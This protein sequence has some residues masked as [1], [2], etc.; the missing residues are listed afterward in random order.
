MKARTITKY[1]LWF[2]LFTNVIPLSLAGF[3]LLYCSILSPENA[4]VYI[5][6]IKPLLQNGYVTLII[7]WLPYSIGFYAWIVS[8]IYLKKTPP[9][10]PMDFYDFLMKVMPPL[11]WIYSKSLKS[12]IDERNTLL[13]KIFFILAVSF[14]LTTFMW[15]WDFPNYVINIGIIVMTFFSMSI[16]IVLIPNNDYDLSIRHLDT[17]KKNKDEKSLL[18]ALKII[19][20]ILDN[21]ISTEEIYNMSHGISVIFS[22][23]KEEKIKRIIDG[24]ILALEKEDVEKISDLMPDLYFQNK[25][26]LSRFEKILKPVKMPFI[27]RMRVLVVSTLEKHLA[28]ILVAMF[29]FVIL[30]FMSLVFGFKIQDIINILEMIRFS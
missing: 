10:N 20:E 26:M 9:S 29:I 25:I 19:N 13:S 24:L 6:Q 18:K 22:F 7:A 15:V 14:L 28:E 8:W 4:T 27:N 30:V 17:F 5:E 16:L 1:V 23:K 12:K 3:L 2:I 11:K 21:R